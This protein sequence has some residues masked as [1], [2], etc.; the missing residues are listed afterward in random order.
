M[1]QS[2]R[3]LNMFGPSGRW[4]LLIDALLALTAL[5][6]VAT[7]VLEYGFGDEPPV[8]KTYLHIAEAAIVA[9]FVL[10]RLV[11]LLLARDRRLYLRGNWVD[12]ALMGLAAIALAVSYRLYGSILGAGALYVIITQL[13][14]L[15]A[16]LLRAA[17]INQWFAESGAH[18]TWLLIGSF[19]VMCLGGSGLLMLPAAT[20]AEHDH[21]FYQD[22][23]F[24]AVSATCVTG[25]ITR[26]TGEDF[27]VFGQAVILTLIQLGGLGIM[28][29]GTV[30]AMALGR[31][32]SMRGTSALG[33]MVGTEGI[34]QFRRAAK[35]VVITA[36][37]LESIGA[38][39]LYPMY[40]SLTMAVEKADGSQA[41]QAVFSTPQAIWH[42]VFHSVS[43][44]CNAGFSLHGSNLRQGLGGSWTMPLREHW[45]V[46]GVFAPL[47]ILGG[48][49]FPVLENC[50]RYVRSLLRRVRRRL[51]K[52]PDTAR[53]MAS[54]RLNLH[55]KVVLATSASLIAL[56]AVGLVLLTPGVAEHRSGNS[57]GHPQHGPAT[58]RSADFR[59]MGAPGRFKEAAFQSITARTAGFNTIDMQELS[60]AGKMWICGLMVIGGSPAST[61][62]GM[63]TVTFAIL[64][65]TAYC[66]L[67]R[68]S[69][70]E[71]FRRS[72]TSELLRKTVTLAV[73]YL[74]LVAVVTL[75]LC[76][77]TGWEGRF[78]DLLFEACSACGTVGLSTGITPSLNLGAKCTV[79][80]GMF[81]GRLGP[82]TLLGALTTGIKPVKY[83]YPQENLVIG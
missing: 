22:A 48:L 61:A 67:R 2:R 49:G 59:A 32:L 56:G 83:S 28:L 27:T 76:V 53:T 64:V 37:A 45:Q 74:L 65:A 15:G 70:V 73:L 57:W 21:A 82:L 71:V 77:T 4:V 72:L 47:I 36:F 18:P 29:F 79:I 81:I 68:R 39:L 5:G 12:F 13:Y 58:R 66:M 75:L 17:G 9:V 3:T 43:A 14:I 52:G 42:S 35:F 55:S 25:L 51:G 54:A 78:I 50:A 7:L 20:T 38:L 69:E 63:K 40:A 6:A 33:R 26:D 19:A 30:F 44:F 10:D 11:R 23:L 34:G 24:T 8:A 16:L 46:M 41:V 62:G 31:R 1:K 80:A 60:P